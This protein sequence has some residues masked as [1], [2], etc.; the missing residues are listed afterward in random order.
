MRGN[1]E[2]KRNQQAIIPGSSEQAG[3]GRS[4]YPSS[5][6]QIDP[7]ARITKHPPD[8]QLECK[9]SAGRFMEYLLSRNIRDGILVWESSIRH[10]CEQPQ[11]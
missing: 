8:T 10:S 9:C 7:R 3:G 5:A 11:L 4:D 1:H 2:R 6:L